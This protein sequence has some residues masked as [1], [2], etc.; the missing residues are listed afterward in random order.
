MS[1]DSVTYAKTFCDDVEF[2]AEDA[3]RT[4]IGYLADIIETAIEAGATTVNI[5]D[6]TGYTLPTEYAAK[7]AE[8]KRRV[9]NIDKAIISVH[10]H[11]DLGL[12]VANS[13]GC[14]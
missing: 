13:F 2:S 14:S 5:P 7:I 4:D 1:Y 11:N 8:L 9:K 6:T 3:G 10:C 12:A